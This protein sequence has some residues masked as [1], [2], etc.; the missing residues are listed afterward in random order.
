MAAFIPTTWCRSRRRSTPTWR[1]ECRSSS[2][3][4]GSATRTAPTGGACAAPWRRRGASG[5]ADRLAGS[6]TDITERAAARRSPRLRVPRCADRAGQQ[7]R[8]RAGGRAA[9]G[10]VHQAPPRAVRRAA[11]R[12]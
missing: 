4:I 2:T 9:A 6:L 10:P 11:P 5:R 12:P 1:D 8:L 3:S 7:G